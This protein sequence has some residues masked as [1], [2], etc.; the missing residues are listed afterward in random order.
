MTS[1]LHQPS[2]ALAVIVG[3]TPLSWVKIMELVCEYI[4]EN[5]LESSLNIRTDDALRAMVGEQEYVSTSELTEA[6]KR[7]ITP[8]GRNV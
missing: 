3:D 4:W 5:D 7:H 2:P 6:I 1:E 8:T